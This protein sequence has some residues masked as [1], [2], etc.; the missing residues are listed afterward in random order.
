MRKR[1]ALLA[2]AVG[3]AIACQLTLAGSVAAAP[4]AKTVSTAKTAA[5]GPVAPN[6]TN[7]MDCNGWSPKYHPVKRM[8]DLCTDPIKT[9]L[10]K[11]SWRFY[12]NGHYV[13]HDEPSVKFISSAPDSGNTMSYLMRVPVDP[14]KAPTATGSVTDYG[15]LS[16]APWFGLPICDS[17]SF[18][19]N[20]CTPDSDA[21]LGAINNA[22]DAGSAFL[23]LQFYPPGYTPFIDSESCSA[24]QWCA[25]LTIDSLE[26][27]AGFNCNNNCIEPVN[28]SYLQTNGVPPGPPSP[29]L[30]DAST[31][32][33]NSHTLKINPGDA[34]AVSITD[35]PAG[36][37]TTVTDLTT[38]QT[39]W[40]T[41][42][43][44]NGF[45]HT[46]ITDCSGMPY[47]FHAEYNTAKIQNRVPWAA[48]EGG[49]LMEQEIG[50]S[51][52]CSSVTNKDPYSVSYPGGQS[53][54]DTNT[55]D[56]CVG[57][58]EGSNATGENPA[59]FATATTQGPN[60][61]QA[62]P[63]QGALCEYGDGFCF[64]QG[65]RTVQ[66]N[67]VP[68]TAVSAANECFD[69]RDQNGDLD[70]DGLDYTAIGWPDGTA[71][72]PTSV[73][74]VGPFDS[75]G[76]IYPLVQFETDIGGSEFLCNPNTGAGCLAPPVGSSFYPYW[77]LS[78]TT[79]GSFGSQVASCEWNFGKTLPTTIN[80]LGGDVQYGQ[81]DLAW[82]GGTMI[83]PPKPNPE[84]GGLCVR[85]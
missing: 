56:T 22:N 61:P 84:F 44:A 32:L 74:Y 29:Q 35:P 36:L 53:Y 2:P 57:G 55:Y 40:I 67:G 41:A 10:G 71:N 79:A 72:H 19:Q 47:T 38:G 6:S 33:G 24:T 81:Q 66:I 69:T 54:T 11:K 51:E 7:S 26:C 31:F 28:F 18:P 12:D 42:S 25:A 76:N 63:A 75:S 85:L 30:T 83:S 23:E 17:A 62:C 80:G 58:S 65:T 78:R 43:A 68:T 3:A 82:F 5:V 34:L 77:S 50:H 21:N 37:T 52:V 9:A 39:G 4:A 64:A 20:P 48:L 16:V 46:S 73:E 49:V 14:A 13:G 15:Q 1:W 60:G 59:D 27:T 45:M 70:F 8:G